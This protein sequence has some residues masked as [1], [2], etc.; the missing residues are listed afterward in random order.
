MKLNPVTSSLLSELGYDPAT[1]T[2]YA[3]FAKNGQL[4]SYHNMP[5]SVFDEWRAAESV[6]SFFLRN[7]KPYYSFAKIEE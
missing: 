2:A 5:Q 4:Y 7:I 3:R 1:Q 6:G